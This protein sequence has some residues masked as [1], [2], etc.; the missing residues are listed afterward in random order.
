MAFDDV[1]ER[2]T[3]DVRLHRDEPI[4][5]EVVDLRRPDAF[6]DRRHLTERHGLNGTRRVGNHERQLREAARAAA[7]VV[8]EPH[9]HVPRLAVR[10]DPVAG[11][12]AGER[13][14]DRLR[15]VGGR[16]T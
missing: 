13:R 2:P 5:I 8:G 6:A 1:A 3:V 7:R 12:D 11:I 4:T 14:P 10:I 15:D 16:Q 9:H